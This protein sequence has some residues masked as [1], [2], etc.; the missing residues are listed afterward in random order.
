MSAGKAPKATAP[1]TTMV[2]VRTVTALGF[3]REKLIKPFMLS[4]LAIRP[5]D[6]RAAGIGGTKPGDD[7]RGRIRGGVEIGRADPVCA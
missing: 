2:N 6:D 1:A 7:E 3:V 4:C 5:G